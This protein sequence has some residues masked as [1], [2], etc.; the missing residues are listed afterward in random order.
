MNQSLAHLNSDWM[1]GRSG[2]VLEIVLEPT[3]LFMDKMKKGRCLTISNPRG[4][5]TEFLVQ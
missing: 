4:N 2:R 3:F 5:K 1:G